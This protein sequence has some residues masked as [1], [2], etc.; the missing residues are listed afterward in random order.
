[1][2]T[3]DYSKKLKNNKNYLIGGKNNGYRKK[4]QITSRLQW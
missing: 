2:V 1:M 4:R 3:V